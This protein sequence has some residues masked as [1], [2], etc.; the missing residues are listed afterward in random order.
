MGN[1]QN[2]VILEG[3]NFINISSKFSNLKIKD[4]PTIKSKIVTKDLMPY[5]IVDIIYY[6]KTIFL[7]VQRVGNYSV[8]SWEQIM[9]RYEVEQFE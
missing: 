9:E 4:L 1:E 6:N 2:I 3:V 7:I 8:N 5:E